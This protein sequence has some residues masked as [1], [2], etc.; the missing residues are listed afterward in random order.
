MDDRLKLLIGKK[1]RQDQIDRITGRFPDLR[2]ETCESREE[3]ESMIAD[4]DLLFTR[5]IPDEPGQAPGLV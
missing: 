2:I 5:I 4:A 1:M 3:Q